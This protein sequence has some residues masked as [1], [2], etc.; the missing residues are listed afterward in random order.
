MEYFFV[1]NPFIKTRD[2]GDLH[3]RSRL[4]S[5]KEV[6]ELRVFKKVELIGLNHRLGMKKKAW[7]NLQ[8]SSV[9]PDA[10]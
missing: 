9:C 6:S 2:A 3:Q 10:C 8:L 4:W 1:K 7:D 5:W